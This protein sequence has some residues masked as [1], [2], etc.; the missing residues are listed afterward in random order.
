MR[1]VELENYFSYF[2]NLIFVIVLLP[3]V[4]PKCRLLDRSLCHANRN[5]EIPMQMN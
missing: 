2:N 1:A 5:T 3:H 4:A